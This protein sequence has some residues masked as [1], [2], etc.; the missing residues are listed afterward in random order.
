[1]SQ[2]MTLTVR[3]QHFTGKATSTDSAVKGKRGT[4]VPRAKTATGGTKAG[5]ELLKSSSGQG[6]GALG[7]AGIIVGAG[8]AVAKSVGSGA[9]TFTRIQGTVTGKR[10]RE[11]RYSDFI[12]TFTEPW[13][14]AKEIARN[15][16]EQRYET[17]RE[18]ERTQYRRD[19]AGMVLPQRSGS[20]GI[21]F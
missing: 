1:M 17:K 20:T 5:G 8:V 19:M 4:G 9:S 13:S 12:K 6:M 10:F 11:A 3:L 21:T 15:S 14:M 2:D 18:L 16:F 7:K